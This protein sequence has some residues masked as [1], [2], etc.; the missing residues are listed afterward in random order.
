VHEAGVGRYGRYGLQKIWYAFLRIGPIALLSE[1][2]DGQPSEQHAI[3][4]L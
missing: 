1:E 2:Q 4:V 3:H